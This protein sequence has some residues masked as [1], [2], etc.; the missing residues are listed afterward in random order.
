MLSFLFA[1]F[2]HPVCTSHTCVVL[3]FVYKFCHLLNSFTFITCRNLWL[4]QHR[5]WL[6]FNLTICSSSHIYKYAHEQTE[7]YSYTHTHRRKRVAD[8]MWNSNWLSTFNQH[9]FRHVIWAH[10]HIQRTHARWHAQC[11]WSFLFV[12]FHLNE[13]SLHWMN[14]RLMNSL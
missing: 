12:F 14:S 5:T 2:T 9:A 13:Q 8:T 3:S 4:L 7:T 6:D 1:L 10:S 11:S